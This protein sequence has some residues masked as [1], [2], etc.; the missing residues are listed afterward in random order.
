MR[1]NRH[2]SGDVEGH[3]PALRRYARGLVGMDQPDAA[4]CA[5]AMV[6]EALE[7]ALRATAQRDPRQRLYASLTSLNRRRLRAMPSEPRSN[8]HKGTQSVREALAEASLESREVLLLIV[9]EGFSYAQ[10]A[11][12]LGL[13]RMGL[14]NRLTRARHQL[15]GA[16]EAA[17]G[18]EPTRKLN[19]PPYLR[20][21][22]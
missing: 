8:S 17:P 10:A 16:L 20:L 12:I 13:S 22:K 18:G 5:D 3:I 2:P 19:P 11:N 15:S 1:E 14:A 6:R 7:Q 4:A 9:V 21:V